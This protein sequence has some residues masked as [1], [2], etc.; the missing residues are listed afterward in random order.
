MKLSADNFTIYIALAAS[1]VSLAAYLVLAFAKRGP[2]W[3][4][5]IAR[6]AYYTCVVAVAY[7]SVY[8]L[9]QILSL[10]RYDI[11]YIHDYSGPADALIY[12]VSSFWA[13]QEGSMLLWA[14]MVGV[15][16][17]AFARRRREDV[18]LFMTFWCSVMTFFTVLLVVADPFRIMPNYQPGMVGGGLNPLL[19]NPWMAIHPP[20][21]FLGYALLI[22][23]AAYAIRAIV[24][25]ETGDWVRPCLP[26]ALFGW[27]S[28]SAGLILGMIWSYE[29]LG[30]GGYW[31]W[32]PVENASF[33]PWLTGTALVHGLL[34]QRNRGRMT[35]ANLM[36]AFG[37]FLLI[38]YATF[39]TR[40]GVLSEVSNHSFA[41]LGTH[42][43]LLAGMIF[44]VVLCVGMLIWRWNSMA[45]ESEPIQIASKD[46]AIIG[47]AVVMSVF[48]ITVVIG[49]SFP[50]FS[51]SNPS[52]TFYTHMATPIAIATA[53]LI[54]F[55][56]VLG[57][58]A[59]AVQT[60][61]GEAPAEPCASEE[62][63]LGESLALP[64][65][66][67]RQSNG[68]A[69]ALGVV[70]V[71][72]IVAAFAGTVS[73]AVDGLLARLLPGGAD[74]LAARVAIILLIGSGI[75]AL[76]LSV[77]RC[78]KAVPLRAGAHIGHIGVALTLLGIVFSCSG[79]KTP[80]SLPLNDAPK[81]A[82]GYGFTYKGT[83]MSGADEQIMQIRVER[84]GRSF[85][86]PLTMQAD[87][88]GSVSRPY[89]KS[90]L[91][92]DLYISPAAIQGTNVTPTASFG[93]DG[94]VPLPAEIPGTG[95]TLR[96]TGMQVE[97][98]SVDLDYV[99]SDGT[100]E[101][102]TVSQGAP[103]EVDG[104]ALNFER[105][106]TDSEEG[107]M[108][109]SVGASLTVAGPGIKETAI[110]EVTTKPLIWLLW[111]GTV[112]MIVGGLVAT[113]RRSAESKA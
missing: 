39:L 81:K 93:P 68:L 31:G 34:L 36:L 3:L 73:N 9:E 74:G 82:Y 100:T 57:W 77:A 40:S 105:Y 61:D 24:R 52:P 108:G 11:A 71:V 56:T 27:V 53:I 76:V 19:K 89:I 66:S 110:I 16:G 79:G 109:N 33:V 95:A 64:K 44:Y 103:V 54:A 29:V 67:Q 38:I 86:A 8:L 85:D 96:L 21:V 69:R 25:R 41:D 10:K 43:Y 17:L 15:I 50:I 113:W 26:W 111:V 99:K 60:R 35:R 55:A 7:A 87:R 14:L 88:R 80:L 70:A 58:S 32:D 83:A 13:G 22:V 2:E 94:L 98:R 12:R 45:S 75:A 107:H 63:K 5:R 78:A 59:K 42:G 6:G 97:A 101:H 90:S 28:L 62:T 91:I 112:L 20:V 23:P 48:A 46:Y 49:T 84:G 51:N 4:P 104:L 30:W 1:V 65:P 72:A 102:I 106:I 37:T 92:S 18:S 47:G